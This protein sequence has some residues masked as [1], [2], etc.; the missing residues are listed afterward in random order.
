[1]KRIELNYKQLKDLARFTDPLIH[2]YE[3]E[4]EILGYFKVGELRPPSL[5]ENNKQYL[6]FNGNHRVLV[7][8]NNEL[9]ISCRILENLN[10]VFQAQKDEDDQFRDISTILPLTFDGVI[11]DLIKS[12]EQYGHQD[13]AKYSYRDF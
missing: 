4:E 2:S 9:T 8:I 11:K 12:A 10:D 6:I 7:A 13:P 1:M 3:K 5:I